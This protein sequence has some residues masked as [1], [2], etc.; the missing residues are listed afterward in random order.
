MKEPCWCIDMYTCYKMF[1]IV[2]TSY[3]IPGNTPYHIRIVSILIS[4]MALELS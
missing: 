2:T 1:T 3:L 4:D